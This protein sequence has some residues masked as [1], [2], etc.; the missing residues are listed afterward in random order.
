MLGKRKTVEMSRRAHNIQGDRKRRRTE[1]LSRFRSDLLKA[2]TF[3]E[4][5]GGGEGVNYIGALGKNLP[6]SESN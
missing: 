3:E 1:I 5:S 2:V 6:G 4:G